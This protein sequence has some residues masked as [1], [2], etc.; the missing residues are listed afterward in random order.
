[1]SMEQTAPQ[2]LP[3]THTYKVSDRIVPSVT[4]ILEDVG[5]VDYSRLPGSTREM[6]LRRGSAVHAACHYDDEGDLDETQLAPEILPYLQAWRKFRASVG[7]EWDRIEFRSYQERYDYCGQLDRAATIPGKSTQVLLDI[8][9]GVAQY[10]TRY[11]VAA[12]AAFF[13]NP[14]A[15]LR[16]AVELHKDET[17]KV[18]EYP[19]RDWAA[20]FAVFSAALVV[21]REK[22]RKPF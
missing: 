11:Q 17:F 6:A 4:Q 20:D 3:E 5:I 8:K 21:Y 1:M 7:W 9:T 15:Y 18:H 2:F 13:E 14:R 22:R 16:M 12:Y 10:W 19:G